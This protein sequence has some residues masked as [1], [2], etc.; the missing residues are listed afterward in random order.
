MNMDLMAMQKKK[1]ET[2]SFSDILSI[3]NQREQ[4]GNTITPQSAMSAYLTTPISNRQK[5]LS[6]SHSFSKTTEISM[7]NAD[8]YE[9]IMTTDGGMKRKSHSH[10]IPGIIN[11]ENHQQKNNKDVDVILEEDENEENDENEIGIL[12]KKPSISQT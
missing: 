1:K 2:I 9:Y 12:L 7:D 8:E 3:A 5:A 6:P 4:R 11:K 10:S